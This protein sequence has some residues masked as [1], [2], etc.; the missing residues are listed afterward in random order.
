MDDIC[1]RR[2]T[3]AVADVPRS[4]VPKIGPAA[5]VVSFNQHTV[6]RVCGPV[7]SAGTRAGVSPRDI[8]ALLMAVSEIMTNAITHGG[9][10]GRLTIQC[11]PDGLLV[12]I[13]DDGPGLPDN[14]I[15][16]VSLDGGLRLARALCT[17]LAIDSSASGVKVRMFMRS[18]PAAGASAL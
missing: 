9:G 8:D 14:V 11:P 6:G 3:V 7:R 18:R 16:G 2:T 12:E 10:G 1:E 17:D 5:A 15:V 13:D 4:E